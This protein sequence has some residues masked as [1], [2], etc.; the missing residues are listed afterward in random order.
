MPVTSSCT[1]R[2]KA[3]DGWYTRYGFA[4]PSFSVGSMLPS[5]MARACRC[6]SPLMLLLL[7][8]GKV[9]ECQ[10]CRGPAVSVSVPAGNQKFGSSQS[11]RCRAPQSGHMVRGVLDV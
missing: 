4:R 2:L 10:G 7:R 3:N 6:P 9:S 5:F 1:G 11:G 8:C